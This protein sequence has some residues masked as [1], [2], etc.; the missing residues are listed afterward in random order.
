MRGVVLVA[1]GLAACALLLPRLLLPGPGRLSALTV[2]SPEELRA[3]R[4][5]EEPLPIRVREEGV[6]P[7][8]RNRRLVVFV[9][10]TPGLLEAYRP[11]LDRLMREPALAGSD[12]LLWQNKM[13][14][15][16]RNS[17]AK[18]SQ[19][20]RAAIDAQWIAAGGYD[21]VVLIGYS[22]GA[23]LVRQAY[24]LS[25]GAIPGEPTTARWAD[26]VVRVVMLAGMGRGSDY[27]THG[28][29]RWLVTALRRASL[30]EGR[31]LYDQLRGSEFIA[32]LRI[33]WV[34]WFAKL[35]RP[36]IVVQLLGTEDVIVRRADNVDALQ[37]PGALHIEV[38]GT[39]HG[40]LVQRAGI[41]RSIQY[42]LIREGVLGTSPRQPSG[43]VTPGDS[44]R[45]VVFILH[46]IRARNAR[47]LD[48]A[49]D[50]V[51]A[52]VPG[53]L[54]VKSSYGHL[55]P[56]T[57]AFSEVRR[58]NLGWLVEQ[59]TK[60]LVRHPGARF[61]LLAH[62]NGVYL[63]GEALRRVPS[64][65]FDRAVL[66]GSVLPPEYPWS[67]LHARGQ[68][69]HL[70]H[71]RAAADRVSGLLCTALRGIGMTDVGASGL[72][73]FDDAGPFKSE[74]G[75]HRGGHSAAL[76]PEDLGRY[77]EYFASGRV[78]SPP[79]IAVA[80]PSPTIVRLSRLMPWFA[81]LLAV[82]ATAALVAWSFAGRRV[83]WRRVAMASAVLVIGGVLL[84]VL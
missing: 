72:L 71:E 76:T 45:D 7:S 35:E 63:A 32:G 56:L 43:A 78:S 59:Y 58:R 53:A 80:R 37:F 68:I 22:F 75:W 10:G 12:W 41:D 38:P 44:V 36:P 33:E 40:G 60:T 16:S 29:A 52:R 42:S 17:G 69:G 24:L 21:D 19:S 77:A 66:A 30:L 6:P 23:L 1:G 8:T 15:L 47:W 61:H 4:S 67:A 26:S 84:D 81:A 51:R 46:G 9:P 48:A 50:S 31:V 82:S 25:A 79:S 27:E 65:R 57:F 5:L 70:L 64:M 83:R 28:K 49:A 54:V 34:R 3:I 2:S 14:Y 74:R 55:S 73:G 39:G 18:L 20:L 11:F 13:G 62:S